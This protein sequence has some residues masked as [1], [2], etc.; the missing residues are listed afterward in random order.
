MARGVSSA[1]GTAQAHPGLDADDAAGEVSQDRGQGGVARQVPGVPTGGSVS[2]PSAL[3]G[4]CGTDRPAAAGVCL[5]V[6]GAV[7]LK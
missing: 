7:A 1:S 5:G 6:N 4:D 3:C 2:A